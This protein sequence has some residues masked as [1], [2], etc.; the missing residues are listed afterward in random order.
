MV[1]DSWPPKLPK[2]VETISASF[3]PPAIGSAVRLFNLAV[4]V[5]FAGLHDGSG[6]QLADKV[7]YTLGSKWCPVPSAETVFTASSDA[8]EDGSL[9]PQQPS[10]LA[11]APFTPPAAPE[12]FTCFL[13]GSKTFGYSLLPAL[14]APE[15]GPCKP[16]VKV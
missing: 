4:D 1:K 11:S 12:A 9:G 6:M 5:A 2:N 16:N 15:M 13:L 3:T 8:N 7:Q 14:D 10:A